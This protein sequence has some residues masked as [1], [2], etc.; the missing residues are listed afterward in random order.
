MAWSQVYT[1]L[2]DAFNYK[3]LIYVIATFCIIRIFVNKKTNIYLSLFQIAK[4]IVFFRKLIFFDYP[5][6]KEI[7][8]KSYA[9]LTHQYLLKLSDIHD[10]RLI[11]RHTLYTCIYTNGKRI[12]K[13]LKPTHILRPAHTQHTW[14]QWNSICEWINFSYVY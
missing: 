8:N 6:I 14:F 1:I 11:G 4:K 13:A 5:L 2:K 12:W 10:V 3:L 7:L 9:A